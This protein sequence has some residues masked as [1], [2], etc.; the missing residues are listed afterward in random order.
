[1]EL[2]HF[3]FAQQF[4]L[5][6]RCI[7]QKYDMLVDNNSGEYVYEDEKSCR[8]NFGA[9]LDYNLSGENDRT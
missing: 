7:N 2:K 5:F 9:Q 1:M 6:E 4:N 3:K 8:M